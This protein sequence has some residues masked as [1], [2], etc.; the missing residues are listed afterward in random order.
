MTGNRG[1]LSLEH[2]FEKTIHVISSERWDKCT[3]LVNHTA[4]R[5]NV[6]FQVIRLIFP[7]FRTC[8]IG[9]SSLG[10]K[11]SL[12]GNF[13][14]VQVPELSG[15][16]FVKKNV[17]AFHIAVQNFQIVKSLEASNNLDKNFPNVLLFQKLFLGLAFA[18]SLEDI[19]VICKLH[20]NATVKLK[21]KCT[22]QSELL[23]SSKNA[24]L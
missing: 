6:R 9:S 16:V 22:Y 20:H 21:V 1:V 14:N 4:K 23:G 3:H 15:A 7:H 19:S 13:R 8:I 11:Q 18:D 2:S 5:P 12:F 17:G 24:Y 10:V